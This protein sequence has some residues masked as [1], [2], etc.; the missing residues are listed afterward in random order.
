MIGKIIK[1]NDDL[2]S[3]KYQHVDLELDEVLYKKAFDIVEKEFPNTFTTDKIN[4]TFL[5]LKRINPCKCPFSGRVH[6]G[7]NCYLNITD[8]DDKYHVFF[9]CYRKCAAKSS[10]FLDKIAKVRDDC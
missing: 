2:L 9:G 7:D 1:T 10:M 5:H 6:E 3:R 8:N 4:G